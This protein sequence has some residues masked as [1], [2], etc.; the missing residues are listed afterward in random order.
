MTANENFHL[1]R[2]SLSLNDFRG[3]ASHARPLKK[4]K[5]PPGARNKKSRFITSRLTFSI[6]RRIH[7]DFRVGEAVDLSRGARSDSMIRNG[8]FLA[9][10]E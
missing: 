10:S 9:D 2:N 4:R 6:N 7:H 1:M 3:D 5:H 8:V